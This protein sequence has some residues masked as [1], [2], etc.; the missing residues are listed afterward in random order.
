MK[1]RQH[2]KL[3]AG[4]KQALGDIPG[5]VSVTISP[6]LQQM[7][8]FQDHDVL[9]VYKISTAKNGLGEEKNSY[10][11]PRGAHVIRAKIGATAP[12]NAIFRQRRFKGD[13]Y[14]P[15][16]NEQNPHSDWILTRI[17][18]LSG[19]EPGFNRLGNVDTMQRYVYIHGSPNERPI[20]IPTSRGCVRMRNEDII[21]FFDLVPV[22]TRVYI[23]HE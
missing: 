23:E 4:D 3:C 14:T 9:R 22:G 5:L 7:Y 6:R 11:T 16:L 10:K 20:G 21:E 8:L 1:Q 19:M 2:S 12:I 13:I 17:L 18:W 15:E